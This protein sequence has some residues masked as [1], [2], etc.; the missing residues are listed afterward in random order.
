MVAEGQHDNG[1]IKG[2]AASER[3]GNG[4][5]RHRETRGY[6][7]AGEV[8]KKMEICGTGRQGRQR[9]IETQAGWRKRGLRQMASW[10]LVGILGKKGC[11]G[12]QSAARQGAFA[13]SRV[14]GKQGDLL[15][16]R[17]PTGGWG[18]KM[19]RCAR[20]SSVKTMQ[21]TRGARKV[22]GGGESLPGF[23]ARR[24]CWEGWGQKQ[25]S[26]ANL[27]RGTGE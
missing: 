17:E 5:W 6:R 4:N 20:G 19:V 3:M 11:G 14:V 15:E 23:G 12:R 18:R 13:P 27:A 26:G 25:E 2:F 16:Q 22:C 9:S 21:Q 1:K 8:G 7:R 24:G 10:R